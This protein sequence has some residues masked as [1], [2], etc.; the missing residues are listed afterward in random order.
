ML[1][2]DIRLAMA[3]DGWNSDEEISDFGWGG[4]TGFKCAFYRYGWHGKFSDR[5]YFAKSTT[6]LTKT[7]ECVESAANL[8]KT[9][10]NLF[11]NSIPFI[12]KDG[13]LLEDKLKTDLWRDAP[14][15]EEW[16]SRVAKNRSMEKFVGEPDKVQLTNNQY[17][18]MKTLYDNRAFFDGNIHRIYCRS[19]QDEIDDLVNMGFVDY[20]EEPRNGRF[21]LKIST[22]GYSTVQ[23][24]GIS[25]RMP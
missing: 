19:D 23:R 22:F 1:S 16:K 20:V 11:P 24:N 12:S 14:T 3:Q 6:D 13:E 21:L 5:I 8:A 4:K 2:I 17:W 25:A 7:H 18:D 9:A 10:W 15:I